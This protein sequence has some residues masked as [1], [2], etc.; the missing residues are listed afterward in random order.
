MPY[1]YLDHEADIGLEATGASL[2]EALRDGV[3]GLLALL[4]DPETVEP[5]QAVPVQATASDPGS[6]FVAL[7]NAV[8]AAVDLHGMFFRDFELTHL[9]QVD[10]H[11]VVEGTLWGEPID[12]NRHAVEIEVKAATYGG[13][14]AEE[15]EAG[16]RL[17]C[18]LDL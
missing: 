5:R 10:D 7:L 2:E 3:R 8:L 4:V 11:W 18:V 9:E 13:L 15:N 12:L 1:E 14:L 16:W 17:R 6:L